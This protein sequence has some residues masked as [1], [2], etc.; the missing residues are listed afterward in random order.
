MEEKILE[1]LKLKIAIS[2]IKKECNIAKK[3][4]FISK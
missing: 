3:K 2:E 1:K 4:K